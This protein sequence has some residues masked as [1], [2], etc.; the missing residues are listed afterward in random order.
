MNAGDGALIAQRRVT[1]NEASKFRLLKR[2][3]NDRKPRRRFGMAGAGIM[4][5]AIGMRHKQSGHREI[6]NLIRRQ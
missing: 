3:Q 2:G 5:S 1:P 4:A 6:P